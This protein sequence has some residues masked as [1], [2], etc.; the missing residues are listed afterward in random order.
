[1]T[2]RSPPLRRLH[3]VAVCYQLPADRFAAGLQ[4]IATAHGVVLCGVVVSNNTAALPASLGPGLEAVRGSNDLLD[5]SGYFEGLERLLCVQTRVDSD[6]VLFVNDS[7][8]TKHAASCILGRVVGLDALLRQLQVPAM[9]GKV[10]AYHSI[11]RQNPW[12][13]DRGYVSTYC[14][15][16]NARGLPIMR[17]LHSLAAEDD[18]FVDAPVSGEAWGRRMPLVLRESI[19]AHLCYR[20]SPYLWPAA[21]SSQTELLRK[22]AVCVYLETRLSGAVGR[23]GALVPINSGPRA[24]TD[25]FVREYLARFTRMTKSRAR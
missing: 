17:Q 22:K 10:T 25:I 8:F 18:V 24:T 1:M 13:G 21:A 16:L 11:C 15:M 5:F 3:V 6:N 2:S 20:G 14:Y 19:R 4:R 12:S 9:A 23:E 7:L